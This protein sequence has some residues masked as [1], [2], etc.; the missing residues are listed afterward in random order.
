MSGRLIS[1][2]EGLARSSVRGHIRSPRPAA[3]TIAFI[4]LL[5][6]TSAVRH[7]LK[8]APD[9]A[10]ENSGMENCADQERGIHVI[11]TKHHPTECPSWL[12][13]YPIGMI[14]EP[15]RACPSKAGRES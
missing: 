10:V 2:R 5:N 1:G 15:R 13:K 14:R 4:M 7:V 11:K 12:I 8:A 3:R 6:H 9:G